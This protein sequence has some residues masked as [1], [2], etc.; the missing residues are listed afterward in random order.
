[1]DVGNRACLMAAS[2]C[3]DAHLHGCRNLC[4]W[5]SAQTCGIRMGQ[6]LQITQTCRDRCDCNETE[7]AQREQ[8]AATMPASL[9]LCQLLLVTRT[10]IYTVAAIAYK[11]FKHMESAGPTWGLIDYVGR[12]LGS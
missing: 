8:V 12:V 7:R 4:P 9:G 6:R 2:G 1:M 10:G 5:M 3:A 11:T